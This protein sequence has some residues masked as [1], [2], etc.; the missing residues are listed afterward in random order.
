MSDRCWCETV[1]SRFHATLGYRRG[2]AALQ[3]CAGAQ[4]NRVAVACGC[5]YSGCAPHTAG[6]ES[7]GGRGQASRRQG[8]ATNARNRLAEAPELLAFTGF[9][10]EHWRQLWSDNPLE[11]RNKEIRR[12]TD[13]GIFPDRAS[14]TPLDGT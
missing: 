5:S 14:K 6:R 4:K 11:R 8:Q 2:S 7:R 12:R 1:V 10:K 13:V 9:P 3:R